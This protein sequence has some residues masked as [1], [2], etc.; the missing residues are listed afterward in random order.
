MTEP[1]HNVNLCPPP[2]INPPN[3]VFTRIMKPPPQPA[4]SQAANQL[5]SHQ[6]KGELFAGGE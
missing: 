3:P 6:T 1:K 5:H 4:A 2:P